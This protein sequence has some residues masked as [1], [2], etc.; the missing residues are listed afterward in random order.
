VTAFSITV[1]L[2]ALDAQLDRDA[3]AAQ[4]AAR[5]A[6]QAG[7]EVFYKAVKG[8]AT[9]RKGTGNLARSI[10]Q[11][12][13]TKVATPER[14]VYHV[15]WNPAKKGQ[16]GHL[17]EFG[18]LQRYEVSFDPKTKRFITHKDKPLPTPKHVAAR[19]F[20]RPAFALAPQAQDAMEARYF[21]ELAEA[22]FAR[23]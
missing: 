5:P 9:R 21:R 8:N 16:H 14:P 3:A 12:Y 13:A 17:V 6:A 11:A 20:V 19:P 23:A 10:Y 15:S 2:A 4:A 1:N 18:Y 7:A 22:G